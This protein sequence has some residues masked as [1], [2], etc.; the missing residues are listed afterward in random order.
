MSW[1]C[2]RMMLG[3]I[4]RTGPSVHVTYERGTQ[5]VRFKG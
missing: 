3:T 1:V 4:Y 2:V 5:L